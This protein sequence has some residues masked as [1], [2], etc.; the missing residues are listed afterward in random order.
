MM[1]ITIKLT[2]KELEMLTGLAA[3]Q[4]FRKEFIDPKLP[5]HRTNIGDI[6]AGKA[7]VARLRSSL[8]PAPGKGMARPRK[9]G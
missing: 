5:G 2:I 4:L 7:L 6:T 1:R 9:A 3:D 8:V